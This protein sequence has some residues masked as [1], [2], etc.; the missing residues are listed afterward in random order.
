M[1]TNKEPWPRRKARDVGNEV[2]DPHSD[3]GG[4]GVPGMP[5]FPGLDIFPGK[6]FRDFGNRALSR[7]ETGIRDY[8]FNREVGNALF[9][10]MG[11]LGI[12]EFFSGNPGSDTLLTPT[13]LF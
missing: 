2:C 10:T 11:T 13:P 6:N 1:L 7:K 4:K 9:C 8:H 12:A 5:G 3:R